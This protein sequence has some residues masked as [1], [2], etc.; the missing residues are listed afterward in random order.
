MHVVG[1]QNCQPPE[2]PVVQHWN[3]R[4]PLP[5]VALSQRQPPGTI[6]VQPPQLQLALQR[7]TP[8][9]S[10]LAQA[11]V[12]PGAHAP[13][14]LHALQPLH[15]PHTQPAAA[16]QLRV[17]VWEPVP[18]LPQPWVSVSTAPGAQ[19][20]VPPPAQVPQSVH[21][22]HSHIVALQLRV[23]D[24]MPVPQVPHPCIPVS[25]VAATQVPSPSQSHGPQVQS[26]MHSRDCVPQFPHVP[27]GSRSPS[28]HGPPPSHVPSSRQSPPSQ[29]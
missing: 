29:I 26:A 18:Q 11:R 3:A 27:P 15:A 6:G 20:P 1:L 7:S 12:A 17:R 10:P 21:A 19:V 22:L 9:R 16:S 23:L 5:A 13:P 14:P 24:C 25:V 2:P 28:E 4:Q 8:Q